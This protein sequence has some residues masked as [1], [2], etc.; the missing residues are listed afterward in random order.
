MCVCVCVYVCIIILFVYY[1]M[2]TFVTH[3]ITKI[4]IFKKTNK[5]TFECIFLGSQTSKSFLLCIFRGDHS[6]ITVYICVTKKTL[7]KG[8]F[9]TV[10]RVTRMTR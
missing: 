8:T 6:N 4:L 2:C 7:E 10:R 9:F 5:T 1:E 3:I